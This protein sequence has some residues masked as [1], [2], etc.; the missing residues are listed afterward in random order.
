[1]SR[2]VD[3]VRVRAATAR[4][5]GGAVQCPLCE[6]GFDRFKDEWN[7]PNALCW[8]CGSHER[9][10]AQWLLLH[11]HRPELLED[12]RALLHFSPEWCLRDQ[13]ESLSHLRYVT[14]D[15]DPAQD[16]ELRLDVTATGLPD[17]AFDAVI[18]SHVLEHVPDDAAAMRELRRITALDGWCLVMVPLALDRA[19][20]YED[21]TITAPEDRR[22]EFLQHDHVRLYAPDI[23]DRLRAAGLDVEVVDLT[24][25]LGADGAA[26]HG[27]LASDLIFLCRPA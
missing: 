5:R 10:R 14:T 3:A 19:T 23:A 24:R 25:E 6:H 8:R 11:R 13:L 1:M 26:R 17:D 15:L 2:L 16:V 4:H 22:R 21:P 18:C 7:R 20:T 12:A 27:L 9:H